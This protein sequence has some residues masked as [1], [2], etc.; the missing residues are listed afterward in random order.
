MFFNH[1]S[2]SGI[3]RSGNRN[4]S[5]ILAVYTHIYMFGLHRD[6][7][8]YVFGLE[9]LLKRVAEFDWIY[10][11]HMQLKVPASVIP[12]LIQGAKDVLSGMISGTVREMHGK[13]I[14]SYDI[15]IDRFLCDL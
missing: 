6:M 7:E 10:P 4:V 8:A 3:I 12:E 9:H 5:G 13:E 11:S 1:I 14:I 2:V 15:E